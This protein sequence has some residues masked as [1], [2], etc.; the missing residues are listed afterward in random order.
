[1]FVTC[2]RA[3]LST[4][5]HHRHSSSNTPNLSTTQ[6]LAYLGGE[7]GTGKTRIILSLVAF[8]RAW[9]RPQS[10]VTMAMTRTAA[11]NIGGQTAHSLLGFTNIITKALPYT[12]T[13]GQS[14][15][16]NMID[17]LVVDECSMICQ[18]HLSRI[19]G[20]LEAARN[21]AKVSYG[22]LHVLLAGDFFQLP[23]TQ[24]HPLFAD[25]SLRHGYVS[26]HDQEGFCFAVP[27]HL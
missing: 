24:G 12:F 19:H 1:M 13:V 5:L 9:D 22:D 2:A 23:P 11:L 10:V 27:R 26:P 6:Q 25:P 14:T 8:A 18:S 4:W 7:G 3:L 16:L 21:Q 20:S 15:I 17:L